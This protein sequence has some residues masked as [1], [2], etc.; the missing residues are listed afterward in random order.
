MDIEFHYHVILFLALK[1]GIDKEEAQIISYS[2]QYVDDNSIIYRVLTEDGI[3]KNYI[4]QTLNIRRP[5]RKLLRIYPVFHFMP[6]TK[7]ETFQVFSRRKD[8]KLHLFTTTAGNL[9]S[10]RLVRAAIENGDLYGIGISLH[11]YADTFSHQ[12]FV[13]LLDEF[14]SKKGLFQRVI[15]NIGHADFG[16][17]PD[18]MGILWQDERLREEFRSIDNRERFTD[19]GLKIFDFLCEFSEKGSEDKSSIER[20]LRIIFSSDRRSR[21]RI[22]MGTIPADLMQY[23]A[24]L[25]IENA[26]NLSSFSRFMKLIHRIMYRWRFFSFPVPVVAKKGFEFSMWY[27]FQEKVKEHQRMALELLRPLI[28]ILEIENL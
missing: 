21:M 13:G 27:R 4:S 3:Y 2:S 10:E 9:N 6:G 23:R 28:E 18:R 5:Q 26:L 25:W 1:A 17:L 7:E 12:D 24:D 15:P 8:A 11:T 14:N 20:E 22:L 19:A 16:F